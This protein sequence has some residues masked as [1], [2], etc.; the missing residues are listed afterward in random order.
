MPLLIIARLTLHEAGRRRLLHAV[1]ILTVLVISLTAW[2]ISRITTLHDSSGQPLP[3]SEV[4]AT[5]AGLV[6]ML[7]FMF[8]FVLAI[9]AAFL[10][11]PAIAGDVDSGLVLALL[12]RPLRRSQLVLGKWLA[13]AA[14]LV[15]YGGLAGGVELAMVKALTGYLPPHPVQAVAFLAG[16]SVVV[17]TLA[18]LGSTRLASMT[19]GIVVL[20][21]FGVT[22]IAGIAESVGVAFHNTAITTAGTVMSLLLP[23]D[24]LW[25]GA[26]YNLEPA[27]LVALGNVATRT[28]PFAVSGPPPAP[29]L[30]WAVAWVAVILGLAALSFRR[31]DL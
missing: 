17:L 28:D 31:R 25:R 14:L 13:L 12:P 9:G 24:G 22:W 16:E 2:G 30:V 15:V 3:H 18:L 27:A 23:S 5:A 19:C 7:A 6:I 1:A 29:Y 20:A 8:S 4:M 10:A 26:V 11:A 21:L